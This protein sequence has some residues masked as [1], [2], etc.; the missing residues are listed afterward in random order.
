M[1]NNPEKRLALQAY[2]Q[3]LEMIMS[4]RSLPGDLLNERRLAE[5]LNMSRTPVRD[6]L[7]M[8]EGEG[9]LLR[10][11]TRGLQVRQMRIEDFLHALQIRTM[12]EPPM[13]RIAAGRV[14]QGRIADLRALLLALLDRPAGEPAD[15]GMVRG[16]DNELHGMISDAVANPQLAEIVRM[17]RQRTLIFDLKSMPERLTESS[18]EHLDILDAL[19]RPD[20]DAAEA[21]MK[22]HLLNVRE[23]IIA[24][25]GRL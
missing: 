24:R 1:F 11:G 8:L 7:L 10:Q 23:S 3:I 20:P 14:G 22:T 15:R 4:G 6:A 21:S 9:L 5:A 18:R 16:I 2:G 25:L 13:A 17:L 12:V 19:E